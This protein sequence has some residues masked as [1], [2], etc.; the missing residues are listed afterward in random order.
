MNQGGGP[1]GFDDNNIEEIGNPLFLPA[2]H[3]LYSRLQ[4][5]FLKQQT[6]EY[7]RV[8][9]EFLDKSN[10]LR[11]VEKEK[12]DV[13]VHL[14]GLQ[15]QLA[16]LQLGFE[17]A[18]E[19][20]NNTF[21]QRE[22][23]EGKL[24]SLSDMLE[25][26][27][28]EIG[29]LQGKLEK[30]N[31]ELSKL[32]KNLY[33]MK[34]HNQDLK[35]ELKL[36]QRTTHRTEENIVNLEKEKRMQDYLID[37]MNEEIKRLSEQVLILDAQIIAQTDQKEE[38]KVILRDANTEMEKI[39]TSKKNLRDHWKKA[40]FEIE[41]KDKNLQRMKDA[42][43]IDEET[44]IKITSEIAGIEKEIS[45][46]NLEQAAL[47]EIT[48]R[49]ENIKEHFKIENQKLIEAKTKIQARNAI[50]KQSLAST[51]EEMKARD[52]EIKHLQD[53]IDLI[54][55]NIMKLHTETRKKQEEIIHRVSSHK[56]VSKTT[57]NL[58]K[59]YN[60]LQNDKEEKEIELAKQENEMARINIDILNTENQ[61]IQLEERKKEVNKERIDKEKSVDEN[62][63]VIK[64]NLDSHEKKMHDVEKFN[65]DHDTA[66]R[67]QNHF[68]KGPSDAKLLHLTK[69]IE[70]IN[71]QSKKYQ[72]EFIKEQTQYVKLEDHYN[73]LNEE[74]SELKRKEKILEEKLFRLNAQYQQ[75][76]KEIKRIQ[77][78][79]KNFE[80]DMNKLNEWLAL[81]YE[82][83]KDLQNENINIDSEIIQKL[84]ELEKESVGLEV[85]IDR[86]KES[87]AE[88]LQQIVEAE[89]Q[90]LLWE[91]N[92]QLEK[93]VQEKLDPNY[94]HKEIENLKKRIHLMELDL[95][96]IRKEQ[97]QI[98]IEMERIVY[99]KE[100]IQLKYSNTGKSGKDG[101]K[102]PT[103]IGKDIQ[104]RKTSIAESAKGLKE[105]DNNLR[106]KE[107]ELK[108]LRTQIENTTERVTSFEYEIDR[109]TEQATEKKIER[110][111]NVNS[112]AS[113]Q[114]KTRALED[115][116]VS[117]PRN[118]SENQKNQLAQL[119]RENAQIQKALISF[120]NDNPKF[121]TILAG[122]MEMELPQ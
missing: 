119:S 120:A 96:N 73:D 76:S 68:S 60:K 11:A 58:R 99:K 115:V 34:E 18:H 8:H 75:H 12:E 5:A 102:N 104:A 30:A 117:G 59:Q 40:L 65:K 84:R 116:K 31:G 90:I 48:Q 15:Q 61:I 2:D 25:F 28:S 70:E 1:E 56:T 118:A 24:K 10:S 85:Q 94:G 79:L 62:M 93:E 64:V 26:R 88:L 97:D 91:R 33:F 71:A 4:Q 114:K 108:N 42:L 110:L 100:S 111:L 121:S 67:K 107:N 35:S 106:T 20:F 49:M 39:Q 57:I 9:L 87:K 95:N 105:M 7:E 13:G 92:I 46:K 89:R 36:T 32:N 66:M 14:Y 54:E 6:D 23:S 50:L 3:P 51:Q 45:D 86:L 78:N 19:T 113:M 80:N 55:D 41:E 77:T 63:K 44:N 109:V 53:E 112:I 81:N 16:D 47:S 22:D 21:K 122:V 98:I 72:G 103:Q 52:N 69:E 82:K 29:D 37:Q 17:S 43:K 83:A 27:L 74:I 101:S 38:A